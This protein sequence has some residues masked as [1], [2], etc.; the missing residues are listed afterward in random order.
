MFLKNRITGALAV[1]LLL[2]GVNAVQAQ[3]TGQ[4]QGVVFNAQGDFASDAKVRVVGTGLLTQTDGNGRFIFKNLSAGQ[5]VLEAVSPRWGRD[6]L[7]TV[8][9]SGQTT[10]LAM[11]VLAHVSLEEVVVSAGPVA[12]TRSTAVQPVDAIAHQ[13]LLEASEATLGESL[14]GRPGIRSTFFGPGASRPIIRGVGGNRVSILQQGLTVADASDMSPDHAPAV[15]AL[16]ADRIEIIRGP[17]ALLYGSSAVGGAVNVVDGRIPTE[18]PIRAI[19]GTFTGRLNSV[20]QGRTGALR[21]RG[22]SGNLAWNLSGLMRGT[23]EFGVPEGSIVEEEEHEE[24]EEEE[25]DDEEHEEEAELISSIENSNISLGRGI[26]GLSYIGSRGHIGASVSWHATNYGLPGHAHHHEEHEEEDHDDE[27][28]EEEEHA[29]EEEEADVRVDMN[30]IAFDIEGLWR[31]YSPRFHSVRVRLA[32]SNYAHDELEGGAVGTTFDNDLVEGRIELDHSL[33]NSIRGVAGLQIDRRDLGLTGEEAFMPSTLTNRFALFVLER[34]SK[35][36][37]GVEAG[38]RYERASLAPDAGSDRSFSGLSASLGLNYRASSLLYLA[39][40]AARSSK[41]PH[42]A[43]LYAEGLHVATQAYEIGDE[44]LDLESVLSLDVSGHIHHDRIDATASFYLN[45]YS[46][47]IY[48]QHTGDEIDESVVYKVSQDAAMFAGFEAE[49]E[50]ELLQTNTQHLSLRLWSDYV[51]AEQSGN[52]DPLPRIPPLKLG[53]ELTYGIGALTLHGEITSVGAQSRVAEFEETTDG[54]TLLGAGAD[55]K[56]AAGGTFHVI[57]LQ[58]RNLGNAVARPH[59][60]FLKEMI[61][62]PGRDFR[63]TYRVLF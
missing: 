57:S 36:A 21:L 63:L 46:N 25:H 11:Q 29:E 3:N 35:G 15:D 55:Y 38:L 16:L 19:E 18:K 4:I 60:S 12:I 49:A 54:Y 13:D 39:V 20:S 9:A 48:L 6:V 51:F 47:F 8:V 34:M 61:P 5:Y 45:N 1:L 56:L 50:A 40:N 53:G 22:A 58:G 44:N 42:A 62:L 17:A 52:N 41:I 7:Q 32:S 30:K 10:E 28:H 26:A 24:H 31:L 23:E 43:E 37:L 2:A 59:A 14:K 27:E 33:S